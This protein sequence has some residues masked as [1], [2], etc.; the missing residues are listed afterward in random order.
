LHHEDYAGV[1]SRLLAVAIDVTVVT[2]AAAAGT[3]LVVGASEVMLG[4][5]PGWVVALT[6]ACLGLVPTLYF[7]LS[8]WITGQTA[9]GLA[10]GIA[11]RRAQGEPLGFP[12]SLIRAVLSLAFAPIWLLGIALALV[13]ERRRGLLDV[14]AGTVVVYQPERGELR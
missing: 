10:M 5:T 4:D 2:V 7:A 6:G 13:D 8:W 14:V 12:R 11:V 3:A 1:V 9:G